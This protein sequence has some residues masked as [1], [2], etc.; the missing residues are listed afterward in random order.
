MGLSTYRI[1]KDNFM[2]KFRRRTTSRD[3]IR[4]D[5]QGFNPLGY[6]KILR[7]NSVSKGRIMTN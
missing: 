6:I 2:G 3:R 1:L 5:F 4:K 7:N